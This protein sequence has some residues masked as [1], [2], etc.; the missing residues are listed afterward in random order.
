[1]SVPND[2]T[3]RELSLV[4]NNVTERQREMA[5]NQRE[6]TKALQETARTLEGVT[7][8]LE[9]LETRVSDKATSMDEIKEHVEKARTDLADHDKRIDRIEQSSLRNQR[10]ANWIFGGGLIAAVSTV[11][12]LWKIVQALPD[13]TP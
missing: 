7:E 6:I 11:V 10:I 2:P 13:S 8:R 12:L 1:V 3:V 9:G 5:E 4:I